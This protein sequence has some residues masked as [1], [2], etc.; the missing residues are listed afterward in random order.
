M[1]QTIVMPQQERDHCKQFFEQLVY[2][3]QPLL[4]KKAYDVLQNHYDAEDA[5]QDALLKA[6]EH[7][8]SYT[9]DRRKTLKAQGWLCTIVQTTA[10]N[11]R[12][13]KKRHDS[14]DTTEESK[15]LE[16][17][18]TRFES[19]EVALMREETWE[20][21]YQLISTLPEMIRFLV[22]FRFLL[23]Y[24]YD[25]LALLFR[26][27]LGLEK[28]GTG[29]LRTRTHRSLLLLRN[30]LEEAGIKISD[31]E[32]W[33]EW[34]TVFDEPTSLDENFTV[35]QYRHS[36]L[37]L[38]LCSLTQSYIK[39]SPEYIQKLPLFEARW[40]C[41]V[42]SI[43]AFH[44]RSYM[45]GEKKAS[46]IESFLI[47]TRQAFLRSSMGDDQIIVSDSKDRTIK[48]WDTQ[49]SQVFHTLESHIDT[50]RSA[51]LSVGGQLL[52]SGSSSIIKLCNVQAGQLLRILEAPVNNVNSVALSTGKTILANGCGWGIWDEPPI[53]KLCDVQAGQLLCTLDDLPGS[54]NG[55]VVA[56]V[57]LTG[58]KSQHSEGRIRISIF[59]G[60]ANSLGGEISGST[61]TQIVV[62]MLPQN[63]GIYR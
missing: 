23:E 30:T 53:I 27:R 13:D 12:R 41:H 8:L 57:I 25:L 47:D 54:V 6:Y 4:Y 10:L 46:G 29:A 36:Y 9:E 37:D 32:A 31:L 55:V 16:I 45:I 43:G 21:A 59:P 39:K 34:S 14:L 5:V 20:A 35:E 50:V 60:W 51:A 38:H 11:I 28:M 17:V 52:T 24:K 15:H 22:R 3:Y 58:S 42:S 40:G 1:I 48:L 2:Q 26:D 33:S 56:K 19:P 62:Q 61:A 44:S 63:V 18:D 49:A 7:F